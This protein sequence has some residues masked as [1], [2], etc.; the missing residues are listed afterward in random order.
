MKCIISSNSSYGRTYNDVNTRSAMR[1]AARYGRCEGGEVVT[2]C[3]DEGKVISR[4][5]YEPGG[6]YYRVTVEPGETV[7]VSE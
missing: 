1:C 5:C 6:R 2:V 7:D 3:T 4:V